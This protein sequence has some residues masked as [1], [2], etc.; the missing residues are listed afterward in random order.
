M[1]VQGFPTLKIVKP[2]SKPGRPVVEDYQ[3]ARTAKAIVE[4]VVDKIPNH[5]KR[6]QDS[7]LNTF[8]EDDNTQAKA[9]LFSEKGTTAAL[10]KSLAVDFLGSIKFAQ[11]RSK[12]KAAVEKYGIA[13]FPSLVL[14]P[15]N[16]A[17]PITYSDEM[18]REALVS[19][20][21]QIASPNPDPAP[22][23]TKAA[24]PSKNPKSASSSATASSA[25][26]K[27]SEAHKSADHADYLNKAS[28]VILDE[29]TPSES[30]L[31]IVPPEETPIA[32]PDAVPAIP[33]LSTP[34]ELQ[35]A[36]LTP[37]SG[38]C[39]LVLLPAA[40]GA[41]VTL[42][43]DAARTL[44]SF[45]GIADKHKKRGSKVFPFFSVPADNGAAKTLRG[46]LG[47]KADSELEIIALNVKRNWW[48]P[49]TMDN[50]DLEGFVDSIKFGEAS[51]QKLPGT[52]ADMA[53]S[54]ADTAD[55]PVPAAEPQSTPE[56]DSEAPP[57]S[58]VESSTASPEPV[59]TPQ[60]EP[61][62]DEL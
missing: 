31:P 61:T 9:I 48:T 4:A 44:T 54:T 13:K 56:T 32:V 6:L 59:Q 42:P 55:E 34:A 53:Q 15:G 29:N 20:L 12:E 46:D 50:N 40:A 30:P 14:L 1:G 21:G 38:N 18:K 7:G 22:K 25:F 27:A 36:C 16:G 47:L 45:A 62:H 28:T 24:K 39:I 2:G 5:V 17:E 51:K 19:F 49:Y 10:I 37:K 35:S 60:A 43:E 11:I 26:S 57:S 8:L 52:F 3:G 41:D 33:T 58:E 23:K